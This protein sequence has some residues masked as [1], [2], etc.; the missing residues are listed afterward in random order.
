M[1]FKS[2]RVSHGASKT[3]STCQLAIALCSNMVLPE[4]FVIYGRLFQWIFLHK[5]I[6]NTLIQ[7]V[8]NTSLK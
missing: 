3:R 2:C 8:K 5:S 1:D 4:K 6:E 7:A